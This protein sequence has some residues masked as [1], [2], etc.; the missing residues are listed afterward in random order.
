LQDSGTFSGYA[1]E[2]FEKLHREIRFS[3]EIQFYKN[4]KIGT[5]DSF[6]GR[7]NG[8]IGELIAEKADMIFVPIIVTPERSIEIDFTVSFHKV[9]GCP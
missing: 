2:L 9:R 7:W 3:Y 5:K 6:S 8:L 1:F 4:D